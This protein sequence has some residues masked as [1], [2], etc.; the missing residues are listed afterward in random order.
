MVTIV[1]AYQK[2]TPEIL[3][4]CLASIKRHT[5][6]GYNV[7]VVVRGT[8]HDADEVLEEIGE[9]P[10][11]VITLGKGDSWKPAGSR[12]HGAMLDEVIPS[13]IDT[14]FV[15]TL[16]SDCFPVADGWLGDLLS[17]M[18]DP[19]VGCA[20]ILHPWLPPPED[21]PK[22]KMEWRVRNQHCW[23]VTHVACQLVRVD[24]WHEAMR[25]AIGD[26]TGLSVTNYLR[27]S[28]KRC[29]GF[30]ATRCANPEPNRENP[31]DTL[32]PE[33]NRHV[34]LIFG[35]KVYHHGGFSRKN[36]F[37]GE[38]DFQESFGWV[39]DL[40]LAY[41]GA[42]FL[43]DDENSY[44]YKFDREEEVVADKMQRLFGLR[45]QRRPG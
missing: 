31:E 45:S 6:V 26:D 14:E 40:V 30:M 4:T 36:A 43:L 12:V 32:D 23:N 15:L 17:E 27:S 2:G 1:V 37:G 18:A 22:S 38:R 33:F 19:D 25:Y 35:D 29:V 10:V 8:D 28:G 41:R 16:D 24:P 7:L 20:G 5:K 11:K 42:E 34:C 9:M 3:A 13:R 21:M 44:R 39:E